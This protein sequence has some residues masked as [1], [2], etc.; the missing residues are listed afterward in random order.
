LGVAAVPD[1]AGPAVDVA[2]VDVVAPV[3]AVFVAVSSLADA[4]EPRV[5]ADILLVL[6]S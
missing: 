6:L 3:V 1:A 2:A 4:A 5:S